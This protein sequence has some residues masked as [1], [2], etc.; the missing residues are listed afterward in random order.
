MDLFTNA[1]IS[2]LSNRSVLNKRGGEEENM[3]WEIGRRGEQ[4]L[5]P[6]QPKILTTEVERERIC[7]GGR[8][9]GVNKT[10]N[11]HNRK[12]GQLKLRRREYAKGGR[13]EGENSDLPIQPKILTT[14]V[15]R[16][17]ICEGGRGEGENADLPIQPKILTTEVERERIC[18]GEMKRSESAMG[19]RGE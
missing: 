14:E 19:R 1:S 9:E 18:E 17:R 16:E 11:R 6:T 12:S 13:G 5:Q 10:Y 15:V 3:R 8:G 4:N 7:D 2:S